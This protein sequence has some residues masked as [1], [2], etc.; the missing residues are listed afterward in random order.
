MYD[1]DGNKLLRAT[2]DGVTVYLPGGQEVHATADTVTATRWYS[3]AGATVATRTG[4]GLGGV[5][6]VVTDHH[7]T[8]VATIQNTRWAGGVSRL[9]SDPF[10]A[11]LRDQTSI[12]EGHGYLGAPADPTGFTLL[13][14]RHYDPV[15]GTF[16]SPDPL[17][18]PLLPAQFNAYV[19]AANNPVTWSDP[20]GET[21]NM[22]SDHPDGGYSLGS[23]LKAVSTASTVATRRSNDASQS[24]YE[25]QAVHYG[26]G[27][28][29]IG[30]PRPSFW[31]PPNFLPEMYELT[32][33]YQEFYRE[34]R[35]NRGVDE[36]VEGIIL[37]FWG[38]SAARGAAAAKP[39]TTKPPVA[40]SVIDPSTINTRISYQSQGRHVQG[41]REYEGKSYFKSRA[42]AQEVLDA[43]H[44]GTAEVLGM[45]GNNV[46]VRVPGV[47]GYNMNREHGY[48][49]QPTNVFFI[50]GTKSV[51]VVRHTPN[52]TPKP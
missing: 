28:G 40:V 21:W 39:P 17:L 26:V 13:G 18:D 22:D 51:S 16:L 11:P 32:P 1:A 12:L 24:R 44:N 20:S 36:S 9:R 33:E 6:S 29:P 47:T 23:S 50:K 48:L 41:A 2:A 30:L 43:F 45:K 10:G 4:S 5:A 35:R 31:L 52:W 27:Q 42:D 3:F 38:V 25:A 15:T 34:R 46:V 7:G 49:D 8:P 19:Y 37:M 14:A